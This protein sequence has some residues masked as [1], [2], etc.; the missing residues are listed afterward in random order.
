MLKRE[1]EQALAHMKAAQA[2]SPR[3]PIYAT[4]TGEHLM[5]MW[6]ASKDEAL[7]R[8]ALEQFSKAL[9]LQ[10]NFAEALFDIGCMYAAQGL[11]DKALAAHNIPGTLRGAGV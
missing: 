9:E 10:T 6:L 5:N 7:A 1:P 3:E 4:W 2:L 11:F 8:Q